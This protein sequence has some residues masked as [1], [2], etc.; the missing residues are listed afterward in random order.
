MNILHINY[1]DLIGGRFTGYYMQQ[2]LESAEYKVNMAVWRKEGNSPN[3]YQIPPLSKFSHKFLDVLMNIGAR[4]GLDRLIG[5]GGF[6]ISKKEFFK[7]A[8]VVHIHIIHNFSN[9][10]IFSLPRLSGLKPIVW[11]IHDPWAFTGGCEHSFECNRW[12]DGCNPKC[13]HPRAKSLLMRYMPYVHWRIKK[14]VYRNTNLFL[15]V[16]SQWMENKI[17]KSPLLNRFTCTQIPFGIDLNLFRPK[18]DKDCRER[19][20]IPQNHNVIAFRNSGIKNDKFKGL[21]WLIKALEIYVP[22]KP[23]TI[24]MIEGDKGFEN[25]EDKYHIIK[26][27]WID[28][29]DI[30]SALSAADIF[31]MPSIQESF[32]LMAVEAMACGTPVIVCEG[33]ALPSVIHAP[34]GG[35]SVPA[36]DTA[37]LVDAIK[38]LLE[39]EKLRKKISYQ[40]RQI[41]EENYSYELYIKR[42]LELYKNVIEAHRTI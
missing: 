4:F 18:R 39:D 27:G 36:K 5:F 3:V 14:N 42:H 10:S 33:T 31:L 41:V 15:V 23:T 30:V 2:A 25:L 24:L 22:Q 8:D 28:G 7:Q 19:F 9:F 17:Y 20:S 38:L 11:T 16:A 26:T 21:L 1:T 40:A 34:E 37:A 12:M 29:E 6:Y 32:G 13:P 35:L